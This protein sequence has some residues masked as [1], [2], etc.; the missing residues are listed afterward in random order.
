M[1]CCGN[2]GCKIIQIMPS[3]GW[4]V[5]VAEETKDQELLSAIISVNDVPLVGWGL[6]KCGTVVALVVVGEHD[7][8]ESTT[9]GYEGE[10]RL[11]LPEK[12][13]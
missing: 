5:R 2:E 4:T 3:G 6:K 9:R 11:W 8:G 13:C 1:N 7:I 12:G 10:G